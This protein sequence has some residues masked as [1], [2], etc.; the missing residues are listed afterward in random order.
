MKIGQIDIPEPL[1][2]AQREGTLVIFAGAGVS[3]PSPSDYPN[4]EKLAERIAAGSSLTREEHEPL[5]TLFRP[6]GE[7]RCKGAST[8]P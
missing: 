2:E 5:E 8:R 4:F 6:L 7:P 1:L 3:M